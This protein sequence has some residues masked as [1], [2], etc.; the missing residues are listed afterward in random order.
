MWPLTI[1]LN[2]SPLGVL[3]S[4]SFSSFLSLK[5]SR[6]LCAQLSARLCQV[7]FLERNCAFLTFLVRLPVPHMAHH[8]P[9]SCGSSFF[10]G[11]FYG[12]CSPCHMLVRWTTVESA[13][14]NTAFL[15]KTFQ[16]SS[17]FSVRSNPSMAYLVPAPCPP[18]YLIETYFHSV[19]WLTISRVPSLGQSLPTWI[20]LLSQ[21]PHAHLLPWWSLTPST[22]LPLTSF[23][24]SWLSGWAV[25]EL[26]VGF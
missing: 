24:G 18:V 23:R 8:R 21:A 26:N 6:H 7:F 17:L 4:Q 20:F 10:T 9:S 12:L 15:F 25:S 11:L 5:P 13:V 16:Y 19:A 3:H 14:G 22:A 2:S 1:K